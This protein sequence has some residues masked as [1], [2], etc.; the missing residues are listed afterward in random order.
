MV[1]C[2]EACKIEGYFDM[3]RIAGMEAVRDFF[4]KMEI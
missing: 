2:W 3:R 1:F 4:G